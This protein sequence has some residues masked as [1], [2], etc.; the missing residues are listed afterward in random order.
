MYCHRKSH[1]RSAPTR[2]MSEDV[3][4]LIDSGQR[5]TNTNSRRTILQVTV[6]GAGARDCDQRIVHSTLPSNSLPISRRHAVAAP[7]AVSA[8]ADACLC[9]SDCVWVGVRSCNSM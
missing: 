7:L 6:A 5:V 8:T 1:Y 2:P 9:P 4:G 3:D